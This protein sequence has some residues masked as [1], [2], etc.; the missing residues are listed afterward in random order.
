MPPAALALPASPVVPADAPPVVAPDL[1]APVAP[2]PPLAGRA[3]AGPAAGRPS[4]LVA[5][6]VSYAGLQALDAV[7]TLRALHAG[8]SEQNPLVRRAADH[9][10]ALL[11]VKA[12]VAVGT[13]YLTER[14]WK[15][16][17]AAA[18]ALMAVLNGA[19]LAIVANNHSAG[20]K[21]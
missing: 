18:V 14:L 13:I 8:A 21:R 19:Y 12:G 1:E 11:G 4:A 9:P 5:L 2:L 17:R 7:T 6:Y 15:R 20:K 3:S 16:N 10:G